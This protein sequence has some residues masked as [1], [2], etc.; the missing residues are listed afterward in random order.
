MEGRKKE[1]KN[2]FL[3][4]VL[5]DCLIHGFWSEIFSWSKCRSGNWEV[6]RDEG[7]SESHFPSQFEDFEEERHE[8]ERRQ[9]PE[10]EKEDGTEA[11]LYWRHE[12]LANFHREKRHWEVCSW[13]SPKRGCSNFFQC[14]LSLKES[15]TRKLPVA[16]RSSEGSHSG[17][18]IRTKE[19]WPVTVKNCFPRLSGGQQSW[20]KGSSVA[21][22]WAA[23][24][25]ERA[26]VSFGRLD[27]GNQQAVN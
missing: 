14:R 5:E 12:N 24:Y 23:G 2:R 1:R 6:L 21:P 3:I 19:E 13:K 27:D 9:G 4:E 16:A 17:F 11:S 10:V 8:K 7:S 22:A 26:Y 18:G 25:G 20:E 15:L